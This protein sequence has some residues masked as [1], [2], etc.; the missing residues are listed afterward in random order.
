LIGFVLPT[1]SAATL[2][3]YDV[4]GKTVHQVKGEYTQGYNEISLSKSALGS[5]GVMYYQLESGDY[6][7]TMTMIVIE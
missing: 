2:T 3:V 6:S 1:S 4:N 7:A 5:T